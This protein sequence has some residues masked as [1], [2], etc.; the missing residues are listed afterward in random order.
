MFNLSGFLQHLMAYMAGHKTCYIYAIH[1]DDRHLV[2]TESG[3]LLL[4]VRLFP[5]HNP[6]C[7]K[8]NREITL[9]KDIEKKKPK[10]QVENGVYKMRKQLQKKCYYVRNSKF[11]IKRNIRTWLQKSIRNFFLYV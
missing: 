4:E 7:C 9:C 2:H 11:N 1:P 8:N 3:M 6:V 10:L 5:R